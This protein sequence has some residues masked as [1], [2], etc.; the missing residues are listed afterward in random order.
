M[1]TEPGRAGRR[2]AHCQNGELMRIFAARLGA[3]GLSIRPPSYAGDLA[4]KGERIE[5]IEVTNPASPERG[6]MRVGDDGGVTW[7]YWG[8][9]NDE[10]DASEILATITGVLSVTLTQPPESPG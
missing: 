10:R 1:T 7:E 5:E 6:L 9:L 3:L 4:D 2:R 8:K